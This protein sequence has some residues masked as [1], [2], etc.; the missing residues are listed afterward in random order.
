MFQ[1]YS[2]EAFAVRVCVVIVRQ[3]E[4]VNKDPPQKPVFVDASFPDYETAREYCQQRYSKGVL[5]KANYF[6]IGVDAM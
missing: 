2:K 1:S 4:P 3:V 6:L 5:P